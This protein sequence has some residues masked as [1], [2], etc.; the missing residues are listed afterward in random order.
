MLRT[1]II[2]D[3]LAL[4]LA[5]QKSLREKGYVVE[6]ATDGLEGYDALETNQY[7]LVLLDLCLPRMDGWSLCRHIRHHY[8]QVYLIITTAYTSVA[9]RIRGL[10]L[11][12]DD[13]LIKP[14]DLQE[15]HA[16]IRALLRRNQPAR[17]LMLEYLDLRI[18]PTSHT[19]WQGARRLELTPK[20]FGILHYLLHRRGCVIS[21]EELLERL[22][23]RE[24]NP[25]TATIRVHINTLRRKL[26][27]SIHLPPYIETVPGI[28]YR[29]G[30]PA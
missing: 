24:A 22:W 6:V 29:M 8:P 10:D 4:A 21:Q 7:D 28:G 20:E 13:Y 5:L 23:D 12:A 30:H 18:D 25:F 17:G 16:R 14:F 2:E 1:L 19:A 27:A 9:D 26:K 3:E 15:M 11:G